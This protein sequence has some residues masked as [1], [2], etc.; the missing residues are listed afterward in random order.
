MSSEDA[1]RF[2]ADRYVIERVRYETPDG[3]T[4]ARDIIRH[5]GA[6]VIL[7]VTEAGEIVMIRNYR[8]SVDRTLLEI[9]AGTMEPGEAAE[10]CA[11]R[12]LTEETGYRAGEVR[13]LRTF[14]ASPGICDEAMHL[15]LAT[16]LRE[17]DPQREA[18]E[19]IENELVSVEQARSW[20]ADGTIV[21]GK[22]LIG[23]LHYFSM[24][25]SLDA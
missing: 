6:V 20:V 25:A 13:F 1:I 18:Y 23:L 2:R 11:G 4:H 5:P 7:P 24:E 17:G 22:T 9:P 10:I 19:S 16:S 15:Y 8:P 21:D 3:Q 14:Y 12:E